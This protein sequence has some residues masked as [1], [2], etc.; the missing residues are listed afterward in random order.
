MLTSKRAID[1]Q[2]NSLRE[3]LLRSSA[4]KEKHTLNE[5][6]PYVSCFS[7]LRPGQADCANSEDPLMKANNDVT[8]ALRRT[9]TLMQ[10]ELERSV[11]STQ[12][13]GLSNLL[14]LASRH[15][16]HTPSTLTSIRFSRAYLSP[17]RI[18]YRNPQ[19]RLVDPR[20]S[21]QPH[22]HLQT[23]HHRS[24]KIRLDRPHADHF[25]PRI[26]LLGRRF[27]PQTA[28][29]R[30]GSENSALVDKVFTQFRGRDECMGYG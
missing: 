17:L 9:M 30:S 7:Y 11:L 20:R 6:S 21:H 13:L 15:P 29:F 3:E 26:L 12:M 16:S 2:N 18:L 23:T 28:N 14:P 4:V 19:I 27:Y 10:G 1:A 25:R 24:R 8:D 5:K 22:G